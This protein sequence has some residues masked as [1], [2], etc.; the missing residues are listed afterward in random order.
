[1]WKKRERK[2]ETKIGEK[3]LERKKWRE[4]IEGKT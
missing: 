4:K 2:G 3:N 1:M